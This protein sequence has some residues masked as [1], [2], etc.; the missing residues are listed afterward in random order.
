MDRCVLP[1]ASFCCRVASSPMCLTSTSCSRRPCFL[2]RWLIVTRAANDHS[3][4]LCSRAANCPDFT[5][6]AWKRGARRPCCCAVTHRVHPP[7]LQP[8]LL[9]LLPPPQQ[10]LLLPLLPTAAA[11]MGAQLKYLRQKRPALCA[12]R[13]QSDHDQKRKSQGWSE[14]DQKWMTLLR[15]DATKSEQC[16]SAI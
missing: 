7:L 9:P 13:V 3:W 15:D 2:R 6:A 12:Q 14:L 8:L 5:R 10:R 1:A 4:A 11:L 16:L